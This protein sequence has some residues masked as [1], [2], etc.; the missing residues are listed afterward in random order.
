M[1]MQQLSMTTSGDSHARPAV[2]YATLIKNAIES[3]EEKRITLN[4]IYQY[5]TAHYPYFRTAGT[6]WK[7]THKQSAPQTK[8]YT[9]HV[10]APLPQA[11]LD[12]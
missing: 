8:G 9:A 1:A 7:V 5:A 6:G 4:E 12:A 2:P 10:L 3:K 11:Y